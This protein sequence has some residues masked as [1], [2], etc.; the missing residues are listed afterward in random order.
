[1]ESKIEGNPNPPFPQSTMSTAHKMR[2]SIGLSPT[3][4]EGAEMND[5]SVMERCFRG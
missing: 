3:K 5:Y 2:R 4:R 1:M